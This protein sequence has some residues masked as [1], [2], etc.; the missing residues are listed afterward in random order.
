[1]AR[2]V[3]RRSRKEADHAGTRKENPLYGFEITHF[4]EGKRSLWGLF[5]AVSARKARFAS[6]KRRFSPANVSFRRGA[7]QT[8]AAYAFRVAPLAGATA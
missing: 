6:E 2:S 8:P 5:P 4:T 7:G 1:M 3:Q